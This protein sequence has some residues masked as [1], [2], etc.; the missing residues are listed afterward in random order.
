MSIQS[1]KGVEASAYLQIICLNL[2]LLL[3]GF[4]KYGLLSI[5]RTVDQTGRTTNRHY[6]SCWDVVM[7]KPC[8]TG[9]GL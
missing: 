6:L 7:W 5:P 1:G 2:T 8:V 3:C 9:Y 4:V